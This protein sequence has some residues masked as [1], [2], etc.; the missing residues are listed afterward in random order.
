[1]KSVEVINLSKKYGSLFALKGIDLEIVEGEVVVIIGPNGAGKSTLL[2]ILS[3]ISKPTS[4]QVNIFGRNPIDFPSVRTRIGFLGHSS[5]F[6]LNLSAMENLLF[7]S[8]I[9]G[10]RGATEKILGLA[11][12][13]NLEDRLNDPVREYSR[14]MKQRLSLIKIFLQDPELLLLDEPFTGLDIEGVKIA[15][16]FIKR[17]KERGK[18]IILVTHDISKAVNIGERV[19]LLKKGRII[20]TF[21]E[22]I[23]KELLER[24]WEEKD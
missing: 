9:Y 12:I 22:K 2:K 16:G 17:M 11:Q 14:G 21:K 24:V 4:G 7:Y 15:R 10:L 6:Y 18:T 20:E 5:F 13:F 23:S 3:G 8:R 19:V 1:M